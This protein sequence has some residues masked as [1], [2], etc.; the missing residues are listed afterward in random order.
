VPVKNYRS[1]TLKKYVV[2]RLEVVACETK[3][4]VP[5]VIEYMLEEKYPLEKPSSD[6]GGSDRLC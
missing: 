1:V 2:E 5:K 3:R 4:T 6:S